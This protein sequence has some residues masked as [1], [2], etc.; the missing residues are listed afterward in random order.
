MEAYR[1]WDPRQMPAVGSC[2]CCGGE[3]YGADEA[4]KA[5]ALCDRCAQYAAGADALRDFA[6]S[7]PL[8][9]LKW[10]T[11]GAD[12]EEPA[13]LSVLEAFRRWDP[14]GFSDFLRTGKDRKP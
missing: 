12:R 13:V 7:R 9:L 8:E 14:E 11:E 3:L 5:P 6:R 2:E 10:I 1:E 4:R